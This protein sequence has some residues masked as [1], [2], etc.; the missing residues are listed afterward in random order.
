MYNQSFEEILSH[1][2]KADLD[3]FT[4]TV[5]NIRKRHADIIPTMAGAVMAMKEEVKNENGEMELGVD[6]GLL[7]SPQNFF[8]NI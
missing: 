6:V 8:F 4:D 3:E 5:I 7:I 2:L 1:D